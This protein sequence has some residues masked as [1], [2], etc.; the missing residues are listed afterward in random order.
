MVV[1]VWWLS[2]ILLVYVEVKTG[3][4]TVEKLLFLISLPI[5]FIGLWWANSPLF[6]ASSHRAW[7]IFGLVVVVWIAALII[8][9]AL[10]VNAKFLFGGRI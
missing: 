4:S 7:R 3:V 8:G 10:G 5:A 1:A 2:W 9:V 6:R